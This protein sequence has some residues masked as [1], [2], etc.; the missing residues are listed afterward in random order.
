MRT[1]QIFQAKSDCMR[2]YDRQQ[3]KPGAMPGCLTRAMFD[4]IARSN[5]LLDH[6]A[7]LAI[8]AV[9]RE[10]LRLALFL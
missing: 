7:S 2:E 3:K 10:T 5:D 8:C 1:M 9:S 6:W 4:R